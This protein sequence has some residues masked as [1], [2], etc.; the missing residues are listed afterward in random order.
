MSAKGSLRPSEEAAR[1]P[2]KPSR[3][4]PRSGRGGRQGFEELS[5]AVVSCEKCPRLREYARFVANNRPA[6][7]A[8][9]DFWARPVPGFGD[10]DA[11]VLIIGL[12]PARTGGGRTGR[13][14]TGDATSTFLV[15]ALHEAGF[16]NQPRSESRRDGLLY[17]DCYLTAAVKCA[18]PGD[19]PSR[20]EVINCSHYLDREMVLLRR[21]SSVLALGSLAFRAY[22]DH[23][24]RTGVDV[25]GC[26]FS[27]G[28]VYRFEGHPALYASY[29][30]SPRNTNTGVLTARM[31]SA[32]LERV[33]SDLRAR[34]PKHN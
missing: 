14:F 17:T 22:L 27:H 18:P 28:A 6:R 20:D 21:L 34:P 16:A 1:E 11:R 24:V 29:H 10:L 31:L 3:S 12:A 2:L 26:K 9:S 19:K 4:Q 33:K 32:V 7:F 5:R 8:D 13:I 25:R 30:P 15:R 23:L